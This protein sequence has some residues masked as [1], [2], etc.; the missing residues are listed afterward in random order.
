MQ[1]EIGDKVYFDIAIGD[2]NVG[3]IIFGLYSKDCPRTAENFKQLCTGQ[4]GFGYANS[5]F[6]RVIQEFMIQGGDFTA[7]RSRLGTGGKSIYGERFAD[8]QAGL[9]LR[10]S[11]PGLLS[12]ANCGPNTNGSQFFITTVPCPWLDGKHVIFGRVLEGFNV[13]KMIE[14]QRTNDRDMP[15]VDCK[16]VG[17]GAI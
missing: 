4:N 12:S 7:P 10:H 16:I 17:C 15:L 1:P 9:K 3:R 11:V 14:S 2:R 13:V 8:E 5:I 6:H